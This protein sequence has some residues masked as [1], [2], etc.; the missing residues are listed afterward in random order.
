V[1]QSFSSSFDAAHQLTQVQQTVG[2]SGI[3]LAQRYDDNGN[4]KRSC[5]VAAGGTG[6]TITPTATSCTVSG[7]GTTTT[8]TWDGLDQL[9]ALAKAGGAA[10]NEAYAYDDAGRRVR[11]TSGATRTHYLYSGQDIAAEWV[12]PA[13]SIAGNPSA[14]YA[15]GASTDEPLLR[16]TGASG[17][18]IAS[19]QSYLA[20]G[21][22]SIVAALGDISAGGPLSP[23]SVTAVGSLSEAS[24]PSA[25]V[26]DGETSGSSGIW[27]GSLGASPSLSLELGS[28]QSVSRVKLWRA[29]GFNADYIV[30]NATVEVRNAAGV[31]QAAGSLSNNTTQDSPEIVFTAQSGTAVRVTLTAARNASIVALAEVSLSLDGGP[32]STASQGFDACRAHLRLHRARARCQR[33]GLLPGQVLPARHRALRQS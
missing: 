1:A 12:G 33:A 14:V 11:K 21:L 24:Y 23:L 18:P 16:L 32:S 4:L 13:T 29:G 7:A 17:S 25:K 3:T 19:T 15:H 2:G 8:L 27:A 28:V 31:W 9:V 10:L 6:G 30:K 26:I 5:E 20:D 22:G